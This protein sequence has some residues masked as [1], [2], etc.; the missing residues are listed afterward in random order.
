M[1]YKVGEFEFSTEEQARNARKEAAGIKYIKSRTNMDD[2]NTVLTLYGRLIEKE[3]FETA[4]GYAF[5]GELRAYLQAS[6][7]IED[8][9]ILPLPAAKQ[10][11]PEE[12]PAEAAKSEKTSAGK[13]KER[14]AKRPASNRQFNYRTGFWVSTFFAAVFAAALIGMFVITALSVD[15]VNIINYE[16]A[17]IDKYEQWEQELDAREEALM[18]T[19]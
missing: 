16:N 14:R 17:L 13:A 18:G 12:K 8:E 7:F 10:P 9:D 3:V 2:P 6:P 11:A 5:L 19:D 1:M 4:V 15:N